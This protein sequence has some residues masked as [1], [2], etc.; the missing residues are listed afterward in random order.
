MMNIGVMSLKRILLLI[1][2]IFILVGCTNKVEP[3]VLIPPKNVTYDAINQQVKWEDNLE[4]DR[5]VIKVNGIPYETTRN[6][7]D[8]SRFITGSYEVVVKSMK[9]SESSY[10]SEYL[11][12][13]II[14]PVV[15]NTIYDEDYITLETEVKDLVFNLT[16]THKSKEIGSKILDDHLIDLAKLDGIVEYHITAK[17]KEH[18]VYEK[19]LFVN[20]DGYTFIRGLENVSFETSFLGTIYFNQQVI[21]SSYYLY[22]NGILE[23]DQKAFDSFLDGTYPLEIRGEDDYITFVYLTK[24][25][26]PRI[27]SSHDVIY[28]GEDLTFMFNLYG[29]TFIGLYGEHNIRKDEYVFSE[30]TLVIKKSYMD[31]LKEDEDQFHVIT[32]SYVLDHPNGTEIGH[33]TITLNLEE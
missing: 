15:I 2:F 17:F 13:N 5:Y 21:D 25:P 23:I 22:S 6:F 14:K 16:M 31:R 33:I 26:T 24:N 30:N 29:G 32:L 12:F 3:S 20:Y 1:L 11:K 7:F 18:Q 8:L 27:I 4:A 28:S 19:S 9:G 10:F